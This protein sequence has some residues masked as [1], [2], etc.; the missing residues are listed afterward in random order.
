MK[1]LQSVKMI[2]IV[3]LLLIAMSC[4]RKKNDFIPLE[5]MTF[6]NAY[7]KN[8]VK[9]SYYILIDNPEPAESMLK[10]EI[11]K[12]VENRLK[13]NKAL[14]KPEISSLNFVFYRKTDDTSYFITHR[15]SAGELLGEEI[16]HYQQDFI[17]NYLISKC[18]S[19]T[20]E[21]IYL[22]NLP[23]ETVASKNCDK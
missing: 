8:A 21:K 1:Y 7:Y 18:G 4:D 22:Y 3:C 6:T 12:Y 15:D 17:A 16:S 10:Q 2:T 20:V 13:N 11:I 5:H 9:I 23:E 19:G 14:T